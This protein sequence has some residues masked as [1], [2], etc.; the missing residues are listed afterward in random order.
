MRLLEITN[1]FPPTLGGIENY[2][3]SL[4]S[5]WPGEVVVL[6]REVPGHRDFDRNLDFEVVRVPRGTMIPTPDLLRRARGIAKDHAIDVI[7]FA[8]PLPLSLLG[9]RIKQKPNVPYAVSAH[10]GEFVFQEWLLSGRVLLRVALEE[11][12]VILCESNF[13]QDR[14][15]R[16]FGHRSSPPTEF[17]PAGVDTEL[18]RPGL[19]PAITSPSA[20]PVI[21]SVSRLIARKGPAVLIRSLPKVM[22][23]HPEVHT[24]IVGGGPDRVALEKL[25]A[26]I[27]VADAVTFTGPQPWGLVPHYYASGTV[28]VMPTRERWGGLQTEGL[29][30]AYLEAGACGLPVVAGMAGGVR[31]AVVHGE[32]GYI[33]DGEDPLAVAEA[34]VHLLDDP[35][36]ARAMGE[37]ARRRVVREFNWD[38]IAEKFRSALV[39]YAI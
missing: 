23:R 34:T 25:A 27:G 32:T 22:E 6:T 24:V 30:L 20:G 17:L 14:V 19:E 2:I 36:T 15:R 10:G 13:V 38:L 5:R 11:A 33:V 8:T 35:E 12:N 29:P 39:K 4:V 1:D 18:F 37:R 21:V 9:P 28:F 16:F 7:H 26:S 31:D 3:Y